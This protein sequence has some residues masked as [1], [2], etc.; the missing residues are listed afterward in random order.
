M[1]HSTTEMF[2]NSELV[3]ASIKLSW[4]DSI[5]IGMKTTHYC[6]HTCTMCISLASSAWYH[7]DTTKCILSVSWP[8]LIANGMP[9]ILYST[10]P[11]VDFVGSICFVPDMI[12][13]CMVKHL[14]VRYIWGFFV[15]NLQWP[16]C[17]TCRLD[18]NM[19]VSLEWSKE[20]ALLLSDIYGLRER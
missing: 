7:Y 16:I 11:V 4:I 5:H 1:E 6:S 9:C 15:E 3:W 12:S 10:V 19:A 14:Q 13:R 20:H 17:H 2:R 18:R 8:I